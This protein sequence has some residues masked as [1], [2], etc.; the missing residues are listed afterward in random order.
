MK[1]IVQ[2]KE[3]ANLD[4][5]P[6]RYGFTYDGDTIINLINIKKTKSKKMGGSA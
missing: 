1:V 2:A 5:L 4:S 3:H 6:L